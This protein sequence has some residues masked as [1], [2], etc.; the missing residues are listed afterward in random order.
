[1]PYCTQLLVILLPLPN[2]YPISCCLYVTIFHVD[3]ISDNV[4]Q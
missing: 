2:L 4:P 1:M 3:M